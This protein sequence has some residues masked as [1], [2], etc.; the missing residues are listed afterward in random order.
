VFLVPAERSHLV[1]Q[2]Y[3]WGARNCELHLCQVRGEFQSFRGIS[4]PTF[5]PETG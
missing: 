2:L 3:G 1:A 4:M 5:L